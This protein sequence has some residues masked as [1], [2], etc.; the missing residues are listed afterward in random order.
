MSALE[1]MCPAEIIGP[2]Q[3]SLPVG[4]DRGGAL[5]LSLIGSGGADSKLVAWSPIGSVCELPRQ[6]ILALMKI[7]D[8]FKRRLPVFLELTDRMNLCVG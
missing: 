2:P 6:S 5:G 3:I 7:E 1:M 8:T 4:D